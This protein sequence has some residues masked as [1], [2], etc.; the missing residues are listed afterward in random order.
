MDVGTAGT[1]TADEAPA[2][3]PGVEDEAPE[4]VHR[5]AAGQEVSGREE[6]DALEWFLGA[7]KR[8]GARVPVTFWTPEGDRRMFC[9]LRAVDGRRMDQLDTENRMG[10]GPFAKLDT[11]GF[12][13]AVLLEAIEAFTTE[14]G[15]YS[16][17]PTDEAFIGAMPGG[18]SVA[19][20]QRF[21]YQPGILDS[22]VEKVR[23]LSAYNSDRVGG[24]Q[25]VLV[26]AAGNS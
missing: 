4:G 21:K 8:P 14:D 3:T 24:A 18:A 19:L 6:R 25:R 23:E 2:R 17:R 15:S 7:T 12:N 10:D 9:V 13:V 20:E 1:R 26:D 5:A 16:I 22:L 11:M